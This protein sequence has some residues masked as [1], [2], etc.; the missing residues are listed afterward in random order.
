MGLR[1]DLSFY[2]GYGMLDTW[3]LGTKKNYIKM[4]PSKVVTFT[5][6]VVFY[7]PPSFFADGSK[8]NLE[9]LNVVPEIGIKPKYEKL[10]K[11]KTV[12]TA[13]VPA[14]P[15]ASETALGSSDSAEPLVAFH[16]KD[17]ASIKVAAMS[18]GAMKE[19]YIEFRSQKKAAFRLAVHDDGDLYLTYREAQTGSGQSTMRLTKSG[20]VHFYG[21]AEFGGKTYKKY[22]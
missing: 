1:K 7:K 3:G 5:K 13:M 2:L 9:D 14:V 15:I 6:D 4:S 11:A 20:D 10:F 22:S 19:A 8:L 12:D 17:H 21:D 18:T 16:A